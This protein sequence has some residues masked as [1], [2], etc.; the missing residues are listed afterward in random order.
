VTAPTPGRRL[1][2]FRAWFVVLAALSLYL[3]W[4]V[5]VE[6]QDHAHEPGFVW[7]NLAVLLAWWGVFVRTCVAWQRVPTGGAR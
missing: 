4:V 6:Y 5:V 3:A 7:P 1:A 2:V